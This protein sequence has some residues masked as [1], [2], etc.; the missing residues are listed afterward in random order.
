VIAERTRQLVVLGAT[1]VL[2][3]SPALA[4]DVDGGSDASAAVWNKRFALHAITGLGTPVGYLGVVAEYS[5][6]PVISLGVG[7]GLGGGTETNEC[8][9]RDIHVCSGPFKDRVQVAASAYVRP[10]RRGQVAMLIGGGF[11]AG[12]Y[13]WDEFTDQPSHKT[14]ARAYWA[15]IEL[16][17]ERR[18][19]AG[20]VVRGFIGY[21]QMLNPDSLECVQTGINPGHCEEEHQ[22]DGDQ[23]IYLGGSLGFAL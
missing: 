23:L 2:G 12:G 17:V 13:S 4:D 16:G 20:L 21:S 1:L 15:N 22:D 18:S 3:L 10:V 9:A 11:N 7:A 8:D 6:I 14:T 19:N 5:P